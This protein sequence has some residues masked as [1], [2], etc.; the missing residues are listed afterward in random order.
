[1]LLRPEHEEFAIVREEV[2]RAL[3]QVAEGG[4]GVEVELGAFMPRQC[5]TCIPRLSAP[6]AEGKNEADLIAALHP[7]P[8]VRIPAQG[9]AS[10]LRKVES[11]D[12]GLYWSL[13]MISAGEPSSPSPSIGARASE[14]DE[15]SL[16]AGVGVVGSAHA[17]ANGTRI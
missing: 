11:F 13:G 5:S 16:Y 17:Q 10:T 3:G 1:M 12:R 2:R 6:L 14:G 9:G 7:T 15:V 8:A 4:T